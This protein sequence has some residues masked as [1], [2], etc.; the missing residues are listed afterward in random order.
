VSYCIKCKN[1]WKHE[2]L[3]AVQ[4]EAKHIAVQTGTTQ[5]IIKEG[6]IYKIVN[7]NE[8]KQQKVEEYISAR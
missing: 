1:D 2:R 3:Q 5:A 8:V 7:I 4:D 6:C